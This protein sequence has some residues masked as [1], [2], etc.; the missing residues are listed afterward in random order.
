MINL[1]PSGGFEIILKD[2]IVKGKFGAFSLK[3]YSYLKGGLEFTAAIKSLS[4]GSELEIID[5]S[6][7]FILCAVEGTYTELDVLGWIEEMGGFDDEYKKLMAH[8]MD[9]FMP[10]KKA[11]E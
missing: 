5:N 11:T 8:F 9:G 7:K 1:L 4:E 10:K 2:S 3:K 6:L